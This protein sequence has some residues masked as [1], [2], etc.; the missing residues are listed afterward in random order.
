[1][2][3][4]RPDPP[5]PV[6]PRSFVVGAGPV[7]LAAALLLAHQGRTVTVYEGRDELLLTDENSYPIGVNVRGQEALRRIDPALLEALRDTGELVEGFVIRNGTRTVAKLPSGTLT[8]TTRAR[9]TRILFDAART[10]SRIRIVTGHRLRTLDRDARRLDFT[11]TA[12]EPVTVDASRAIVLACDGVWS[13]ARGSL[14]EAV[15]GFHPVVGDWGVQFRVLFPGRGD[16]ARS[17]PRAAPHLH[18]QG[19]LHRHPGERRLVHRGHGDHGRP[20]RGPPPLHGRHGR[21]RRR[22]ACPPGRA[23]PAR[24]AAAARGG[25]PGLLLPQALRRRGRPVPTHRVRRMARPA[26]RRRAQRHPADR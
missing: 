2:T 25:L 5:P 21:E 17:G 1:M 10:E 11:T 20:R 12:D 3:R 19:H 8:G 4:P 23:R 9:L 13:P 15:P 26:R 6:P 7:G 16:R 14:A 18:E 24:P 22:T